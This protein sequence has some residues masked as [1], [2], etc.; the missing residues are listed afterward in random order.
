MKFLRNLQRLVWSWLTCSA[1]PLLERF[2]Y[3][4]R[5]LTTTL[6]RRKS[7][8]YL[9]REFRFDNFRTPVLLLGYPEDATNLLRWLPQ[10]PRTVLDVGGNIGQFS[11][12]LAHFLPKLERLDVFEANDDLVS[13]LEAN[14]GEQASIYPYG[15]GQPGI[16][17]FYCVNGASV[18]SSLLAERATW[19]G[20]DPLKKQ[21]EFVCDIEQ[22][23]GL[24]S[25]DLVKV[26]VEGAEFSVLSHLNVKSKFMW[27]ELSGCNKPGAAYITSDLYLLINKRFGAFN[28]LYQSEWQSDQ[29]CDVLLSFETSTSEVGG[30]EKPD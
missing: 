3:L 15:V 25:Y 4:I 5:V 30:Q 23:T 20:R 6:T 19:R 27:L 18:G 28:V 22:Q 26:D 17:E 8:T 14:L 12:T 13:Y 7:I 16:Q 9:G 29:I 11:F 1:I 2:S 24:K 10:P 21:V